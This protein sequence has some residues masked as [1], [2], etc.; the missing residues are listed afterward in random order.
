M[1]RRRELI[2]AGIIFISL[3]MILPAVA[4]TTII[5][6]SSINSDKIPLA[7]Q[8]TTSPKVEITHPVRGVYIKDRKIIPRLIRLTLIIGAITIE[9][10]ATD[11]ESGIDR[12]EFY[13]G[14][15]G[16]KYLGNATTEP[17][18]FTWKRD[19]IRF[20]HIQKLKVIAYD[21]EGNNATDKIIVRRIL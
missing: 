16:T 13:G 5:K 8:D 9:V 14:I 21:N 6:N 10:N 4:E 20:I 3:T 19:R 1:K 18:N 2:K 15:L 12:V 11:N 7:F 17:Y